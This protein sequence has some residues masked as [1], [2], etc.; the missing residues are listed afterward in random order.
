MVKGLNEC[1]HK[2]GR[3]V[4]RQ[5]RDNSESNNSSI[6]EYQEHEEEVVRLEQQQEVRTERSGLVC[7]LKALKA[8]EIV[9]RWA[10]DF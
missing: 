9:G 8:N 2:G 5:Q 6:P 1:R 10:Q 4:N 7:L 3:A